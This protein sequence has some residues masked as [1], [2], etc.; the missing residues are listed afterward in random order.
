[1]KRI[2]ILGS[3]GSIGRQCLNVVDSLPGK[4]EVVAIAAGSNVE[5]AAEQ[6]AKHRPRIVSVATCE[7]A[8]E[9]RERL[10][11][12]KVEP[13]PE[14]LCGVDG[15]ERVATHPDADTL[16]SAAVGVVGLPA[17]YKAVQQGKNLALANK[18]V[19]VAAG[20]LVMAAALKQGKAVLP[21]DSEHNAIHQ[22][23]RAGERREVKKLVLTASGGPFRKMPASKFKDVTP[24]QALAHP[25]WKMGRRI[26]T[27]SATLMNKGFEV[28]EARW[29]FGMQPGQIEVVIH[30]QSTIHS[31]VEFVDGS[32]LAQL[33]PTDMRMPIQYAL[34]YPER[35]A[36]NGVA[37]DWKSLKKLDFEPVPIR[38]FPCLRLA[39][40]AMERGGALPC[41]LNAADEESVAAFLEGR[42]GFTGI[43]KVIE[44]VLERMPRVTFQSMDDVLEADKEARRIAREEI[45]KRKN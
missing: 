36:S 44:R 16:L 43:P 23:L 14:I 18:E 34:T 42:L 3:T 32:I 22:C 10:A 8:K 4:F 2:S 24:E 39:R 15:M 30:P 20:E 17:T 6:T 11:A 35:V 31:M 45:Q 38:K 29:L 7:G 28:I 27:D 5:L 26:T 9:L 41:A 33:G 37:L 40:E 19:L 1:M 13:L 25:N 12:M 21:V